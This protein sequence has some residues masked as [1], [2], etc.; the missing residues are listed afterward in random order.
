MSSMKV[1]D[2]IMIHFQKIISELLLEQVKVI[3]S[4]NYL[5]SLKHWLLLREELD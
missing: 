3:F 1:G 2:T 4:K 5:P